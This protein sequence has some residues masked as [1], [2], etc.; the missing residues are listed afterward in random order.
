[1]D[2]K[3]QAQLDTVLR[4]RRMIRTGLDEK[5]ERVHVT[6]YAHDILLKEEETLG[7]LV[8]NAAEDAIVAQ[9]PTCRHS[10]RSW[11][12]SADGHVICDDCEAERAAHSV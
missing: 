2:A 9:V 3:S 5:G 1:M 4:L 10:K 8:A 7:K 6:V 11:S 12:T